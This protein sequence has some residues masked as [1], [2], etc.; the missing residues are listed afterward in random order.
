M[1]N[2]S[3]SQEARRASIHKSALIWGCIGGAV[4]ALIALWALGG[5][6]AAVRFGGAVVLGAG[7]GFGLFR[8]SFNS[9]SKSAQ[10]A[11]CSAAF[12]ISRTDR[13]EKVLGS[14]AK[15]TRELAEDK[16]TKVTTW[17]EEAY[18]VTETFTCAKCGDVTTKT[19]KSSRK[20]DE[21]SA[22]EAAVMGVAAAAMADANADDAESD[23]PKTM[24]GAS[25]SGE[26][27]GLNAGKD[28]YAAPADAGPS[29]SPAAD[30]STAKGKAKPK[31]AAQP[32]AEPDDP[33]ATEASPPAEDEAKSTLSKGTKK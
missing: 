1:S 14:E 10:C 25:K 30:V 15:E 31:D 28:K 21:T 5:Q 13:S 7:V 23:A 8:M 20:R 12:S 6:G 27:S 18:E 3:E 19:H 11:K 33:F 16:S 26:K 29:R 22:I 17:T 2:L 24:S 9:G 4:V 32:V